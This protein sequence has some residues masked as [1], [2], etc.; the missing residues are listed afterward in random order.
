VNLFFLTGA[1][2]EVVKDI[3]ITPAEQVQVERAADWSVKG[4]SYGNEHG[5]RPATI[6]L[7][8]STNP[9]AMLAW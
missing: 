9:L 1:Q 7:V 3:P 6:S 8:L 4:T 5:T 2:N